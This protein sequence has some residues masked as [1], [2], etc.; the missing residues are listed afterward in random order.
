M[1][2]QQLVT[3]LLQVLESITLEDISNIPDDHQHIVAERIEQ[4]HDVVRA[5]KDMEREIVY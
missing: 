5:M 4:L 2:Q 1:N 3:S